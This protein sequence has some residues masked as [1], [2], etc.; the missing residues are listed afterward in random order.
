MISPPVGAGATPPSYAGISITP[1]SKSASAALLTCQ[2]P[3]S[4]NPNPPAMNSSQVA[5]W[6]FVI[7]VLGAYP[8]SIQWVQSSSASMAAG[9]DRSV[10]SAPFPQNH[11]RNWKV[12]SS[13]L[14]PAKVIPRLPVSEIAPRASVKLSQSVMED[15]KSVG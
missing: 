2:V 10:S 11:G 14:I 7:T 12:P 9:D 1:V 4:T 3:F 6:E 5:F 15:R 13:V 8:S